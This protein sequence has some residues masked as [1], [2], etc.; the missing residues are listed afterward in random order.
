MLEK[1]NEDALENVTGGFDTDRDEFDRAWDQKMGVIG[2]I[3]RV[4]LFDKWLSSGKKMSAL[5]Y[6]TRCI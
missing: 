4:E 6:L 5:E 3:D 1:I 2:G